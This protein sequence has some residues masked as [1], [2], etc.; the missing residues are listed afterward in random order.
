[1]M[2]TAWKPSLGGG[3]IETMGKLVLRRQDQEKCDGCFQILVEQ[4]YK[5]EYSFRFFFKSKKRIAG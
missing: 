5:K 1:M 4:S 2:L 3:M